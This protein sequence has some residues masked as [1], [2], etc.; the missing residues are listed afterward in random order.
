MSNT[1]LFFLLL[2]LFF[3][4]LNSCKN[5][6]INNSESTIVIS[7]K[8]NQNIELVNNDS[9]KTIINI[10]NGKIKHIYKLVNDNYDGEILRFHDNGILKLK[11]NVF[12][13]VTNTHSYGFYDNGAIK[14]FTF[15]C[16]FYPCHFGVEYWNNPLSTVK[17]S[18]H[19]GEKGKII[20]IKIFD[21]HG[22]HI[23]D[24]IPLND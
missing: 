17:K 1:K 21:E 2:L 9:E 13:G 4:V 15:Y 14:D 11:T 23:K 24:S 8:Q 20:K 6:E 7:T 10:D 22:Y 3:S 12:N 5:K 19:Y 16:D 18:I